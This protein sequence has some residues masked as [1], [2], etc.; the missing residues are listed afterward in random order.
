MH[1]W[2]IILTR[3]RHLTLRKATYYNPDG[4]VPD[5]QSGDAGSLHGLCVTLVLPQY[6]A[7]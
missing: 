2:T 4:D 7:Y 5:G 6:R 3:A 1:P